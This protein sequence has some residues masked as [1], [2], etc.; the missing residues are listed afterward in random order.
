MS[1]AERIRDYVEPAGMQLTPAKVRVTCHMDGKSKLLSIDTTVLNYDRD[2]RWKLYSTTA[3]DITLTTLSV[4]SVDEL[5]ASL[6]LAADQ[7][8]EWNDERKQG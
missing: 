1:N 3:T 2:P 4:S 8:A 7:I 6:V 5:V